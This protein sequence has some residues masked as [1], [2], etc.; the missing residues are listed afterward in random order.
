MKE[1][2]KKLKGSSK[3]TINSSTALNDKTM[4]S[5]FSWDR[6]VLLIGMVVGYCYWNLIRTLFENSTQF[7]MLSE[8]EREMSF[9]T[10]QGLYYSYYKQLV[11]GESLWEE[12]THLLN[13]DRTEQPNSINVLQRFNLLPELI[14]GILYRSYRYWMKESLLWKHECFEVNRGDSSVVI[15]C[16]GLGE[17]IIFYSECFFLLQWLMFTSYFF[18][19]YFFARQFFDLVDRYFSKSFTFHRTVYSILISIIACSFYLFHLRYATR[20]MWTLPLRETVSYPFHILQ[21]LVMVSYL[22]E[23]NKRNKYDMI[24]WKLVVTNV[25]YL[26]TWQFA[27]FQLTTQITGEQSS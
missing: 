2:R 26:L 18:L 23:T 16:V 25:I 9:R 1:K 10:E 15:S 4:M 22:D 24:N 19:T 8:M 7:S 14:I 12:F 21:W 6:L 20:V 27:Q 13:D 11:N 17:P 3:R 5:A